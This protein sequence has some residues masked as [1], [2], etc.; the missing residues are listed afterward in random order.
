MNEEISLC[1][2]N[3][4]I[5]PAYKVNL[6]TD[7]DRKLVDEGWKKF[8][9]TG[10][11]I[12]KEPYC[13]GCFNVPEKAPLWSRC[14]IRRCVLTNK[15]ENCGYCP[16]YPCSRLK[17]IIYITKKIA[18]R[19]KKSGTKDDFEKFALPFL[20]EQKL[21][22][23]HQEF[24]KTVQNNE[25]QP[26]NAHTIIFPEELNLKTFSETQIELEKSIETLQYLHT[27][28][29]S[30]L[31]LHCK[32]PGG[33]EQELKQNKEN[34]KFL[35]VIGR[36]GKLITSTDES[37]IEITAKEIKKYLKYGKYRTTNKLETLARHGIKGDFIEDKIT[38][39]FT[40]KPDAAFALQ[41]YITTLLENI[42]ERRAFTKFWKADMNVFCS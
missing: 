4:G 32:T 1:G 13:E 40:K 26:V 35:W 17:N 9:R 5:C 39:M 10:G 42:S 12:Y 28:L 3:C 7:E 31:T 6:K 22:E 23:M 27:T 11:W 20:G 41:K 37:S 2:F 16:D 33:Q 24:I 18:E 8:H 25:F 34:L 30:M 38:I 29:E 15:V 19:T 14:P 21:E 36:Y